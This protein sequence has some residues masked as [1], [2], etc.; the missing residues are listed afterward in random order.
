MKVFLTELSVIVSLCILPK[1]SFA[2]GYFAI[3]IG[4]GGKAD[5]ANVTIEIG[6]I[7]T[8]R[9]NNRL[10]SIGLAFIFNKNYI[11]SD[12][13]KYPCPHYDYNDL[14]MKH[15]EFDFLGKYGKDIIKNKGL[16]TFVL[17]GFSRTYEVNLVRSNSTGWYYEQSHSTKYNLI[18]GA[19][20]SYFPI[21]K[22]ISFQ[23]E[24]D[25]RRG[26]TGGIGYRPNRWN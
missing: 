16:F 9:N 25:N 8:N 17:G 7:S 1:T 21:N 18:F 11:P 20:M 2:E 12:I 14:G 22:K 5:A 6:K 19:G 26:I 4:N 24:Y 3:G 10:L 15:E 23:V 13:N